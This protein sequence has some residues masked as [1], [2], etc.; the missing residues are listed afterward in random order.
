LR[1]TADSHPHLRLQ[2]KKVKEKTI[3]FNNGPGNLGYLQVYILR[4]AL[5]V[6]NV[7]PLSDVMVYYRLNINPKRLYDA[8]RRLVLRG[9][10]SKIRRGLYKLEK[11]KL[12]PKDLDIIFSKKVTETD[13]R[14][15]SCGLSI[16]ELGSIIR[17]HVF[18]CRS[19]LQFYYVV[20]AVCRLLDS[21]RIRFRRFLRDEGVPVRIIVSIARDARRFIDSIKHGVHII[22]VHGR[23]GCGRMT[24]L[25]PLDVAGQKYFKEFGIDVV[26]PEGVKLSRF[27]LK[28]YTAKSP[29]KANGKGCRDSSRCNDGKRRN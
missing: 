2:L 14:A 24:S 5:S 7:F 1:T 8:A 10:L 16:Y 15:G 29:Y 23:P 19:L 28:I 12:T 6:A 27:H 4:Y 26:P 13:S 21:I 3:P 17:I 18:N 9:F 11:C 22:G 20:E 25:M